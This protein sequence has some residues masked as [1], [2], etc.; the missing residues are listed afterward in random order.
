MKH[1]LSAINI[2]LDVEASVNIEGI[3]GSGGQVFPRLT[4]PISFS[5]KEQPGDPSSPF[6]QAVSFNLLTGELIVGSERVG[7]IRPASIDQ[8]GM[9]FHLYQD[10][11][12]VYLEIP[13]DPRRIEWL[14]KTRAGKS[15]EGTLNLKLSVQVFGSLSTPSNHSSDSKTGLRGASNIQGQVPFRIP[16]TQWRERVLPA[17]GYGK[18]LVIELPAIDLDACKAMELSFKALEKARRHFDHGFYDEAVAACRVA[19]EPFFEYVDKGDGSGKRIPKLKKSWEIKLGAATYE[20]LD[21]AFG[22]I[23]AD[24]NKSH[25]SPNNHFDRLGAQM[26]LMVTTALIAYAGSHSPGE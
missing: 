17:L 1:R 5:I 14:E 4:I 11:I 6:I 15:L 10:E 21:R 24:T 7:D 20:W 22:A 2:S 3:C 19:M 8:V 13:L 25:H 9:R 26:L 23:K 16:D 18:I 12:P